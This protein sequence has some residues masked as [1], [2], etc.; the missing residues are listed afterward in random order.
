M[1]LRLELP[2]GR[3][4]LADP[5]A[6]RPPGRPIAELEAFPPLRLPGPTDLGEVV[7]TGPDASSSRLDRRT[8]R[9]FAKAYA[10]AYL[11]FGQ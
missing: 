1:K 10:Q 3:C 5:G 7:Y 4:F 8:V 11:G 9:R 6:F 2:D